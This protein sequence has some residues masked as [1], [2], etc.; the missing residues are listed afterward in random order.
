MDEIDHIDVI[1]NDEAVNHIETQDVMPNTRLAALVCTRRRRA[2]TPHFA[3][4]TPYPPL[5]TPH[6]T[7]GPPIP[8]IPP[9]DTRSPMWF[10]HAEFESSPHTTAVDHNSPMAPFYSSPQ[11]VIPTSSLQTP[12]VELMSTSPSHT[13]HPPT[14]FSPLI[15]VAQATQPHDEHVEQGQRDQVEQPHNANAHAPPKQKLT[16]TIQP[17]RCSIG[18]HLLFQVLYCYFYFIYF[19]WFYVH[20]FV[21][22]FVFLF[23][24]VFCFF[25]FFVFYIYI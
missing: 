12:Q 19:S 1:A 25:V 16:C 11:K 3:T 21:F 17:K 5:S 24:F 18:S 14:S 4:K 6:D 22:F 7:T 9:I 20:D 15:H 8:P 23:C 13:Q 10:T 2:S